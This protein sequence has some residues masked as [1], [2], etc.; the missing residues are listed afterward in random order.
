MFF[1]SVFAPPDSSSAV[2]Y[3]PRLNYSVTRELSEVRVTPSNILKQLQSLDVNKASLG[4]PSKLL[5]ACANEISPSLCRLFN[6]S[7]EL[8][9]FPEKWK[10]ANLVPIH[11]CESKSMVSKYRGISLLDV[12]SKILE[13]QVYNEI[14]DIICPHLTHWQHGFLPGKST[15]S[16]LSQV[17]HHF[18]V[19]LERRQQV[20]VIYLDFSKAFDRVSHEKLLF[21]LECLGI[22]GSLLAWFRSYLSGRRHRVVIDNESS[23]FL[24]VTS[25]VPQGS[26]LGPLL[27]LIFINDM[28][29][30]ISKET[31]LPLFADDSKCFRVILGSDDGVKLQDDLN[32]LFQWSCI[33]G[34]DFNAKKCKVLRVARIRSIDDRDYY[35]GGIKL[36]RVDVEKDLG[37]LVSNNLSWNNHVDVISSKAQKMLNVLYRTCKDIND[38]RTKKLLYIAWVRSRLEYASVVW[39]PHTKRNI[40]NLEQVQRRATRFIL[41]RDYSEYERLSKLNLLPLEYRR[42]INDLVFFFKCLKNVCKLN[43]LDYVSFRSCTKPL[44][45]VDHLTLDVP[46]SRTDVFKNSFFVRIC[47]LW[48]D[49]P[50]GIRE[51]NTLSIFRKNL[52]AFYYDKFNANFF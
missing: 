23:D 20:D 18:A 33:W 15:V 17:V 14:F 1:H 22:G 29:N 52:I 46:F 3:L 40:N 28:P 24:P 21:K 5:R 44:R 43:I 41:G 39:S 49:L 51:S 38:I 8:G 7:L 2:I 4:L 45:N 19:A 16:Q 50:L 35:L 32:K 13:R 6:L 9:T 10:D 11:K 47:Y 27:F 26:I 42:E 25:G 34:M 12:L 48:N 31:S 30:V 37:I 36:D